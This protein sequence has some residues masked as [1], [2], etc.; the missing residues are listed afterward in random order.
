MNETNMKWR[1]Y[2]K[3]VTDIVNTHHHR[4][5]M[6]N[7]ASEFKDNDRSGDG[8]GDSPCQCCRTHDGVAAYGRMRM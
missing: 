2:N 7:L 1:S 3:K 5:N 6:C 4:K 8:V